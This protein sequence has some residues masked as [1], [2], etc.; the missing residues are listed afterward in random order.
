LAR[1]SQIE[2]SSREKGDV[3]GKVLVHATLSLGGFM[4]GPNDEMDWVFKRSG[5]NKVGDEVMKTTGDVVV[6]KRHDEP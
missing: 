5:P 4:A 2:S 6:G 3:M 1:S